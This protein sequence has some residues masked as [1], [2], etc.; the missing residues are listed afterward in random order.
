MQIADGKTDIE[1]I[2]D[3]EALLGVEQVNPFG[4]TSIKVLEAKLGE[5]G[6]S[7][8]QT[9]AVQV[10]ILPSGNKITIKN[11][12]KKAFQSHPGAGAAYHIGFEQPLV[13]PDSA[14]AK[15]ILKILN[16]NV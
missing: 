15:N 8:L 3:L 4:T 13:D 16:E 5:M 10:G 14:Q 1:K 9:F 12:I 7:D 2:K 11:R 6:L